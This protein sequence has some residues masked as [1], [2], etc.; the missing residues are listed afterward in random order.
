MLA[1]SAGRG[2]HGARA[3]GRPPRGAQH[4]P[5]D[6]VVHHLPP[7]GRAAPRGGYP[8]AGVLGKPPGIWV[9]AG[10]RVTRRRSGDT[11]TAGTL[12][13]PSPI[14]RP[15]T[16]QRRPPPPQPTPPPTS[17]PAPPAAAR[18]EP[19]ALHNPAAARQHLR[20]LGDQEVLRLR[21]SG[22]TQRIRAT[23]L[24]QAATLGEGVRD[25][26]FVP[27]STSPDT[28]A[29]HSPP[30]TARARPP[31]GTESGCPPSTGGDT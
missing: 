7:M 8:L 10:K 30:Q 22:T 27:S 31:R 19:Y 13:P 25:F 18:A 11:A 29:R 17:H 3:K 2:V 28:T 9:P 5:A 23:T 24:V 20:G 14:T 1:S 15:H 12:P 4:P 21:T 26:L 6:G 16:R